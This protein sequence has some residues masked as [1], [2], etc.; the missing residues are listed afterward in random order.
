MSGSNFGVITR[1]D[2]SFGDPRIIQF[3]L[4]FVF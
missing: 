3:G 1:T 4:K 2:P